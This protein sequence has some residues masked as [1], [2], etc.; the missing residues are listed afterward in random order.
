MNQKETDA[1]FDTL[2]EALHAIMDIRAAFGPSSTYSHE[3]KKEK[4]LS[5]LY[6]SSQRLFTQAFPNQMN[7][8]KES[9]S[10]S[11]SELEPA[12]LAGTKRKLNNP[13]L[14]EK[15]LLEWSRGDL[16]PR[17][18]WQEIVVHVA[19]PEVNVCVYKWLDRR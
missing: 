12:V 13:D 7:T 17:I 8:P 18:D 10:V 11:I 2:I 16:K 1:L 6:T 9:E 5:C 15:D 14:R 4:A 19:D 3:N